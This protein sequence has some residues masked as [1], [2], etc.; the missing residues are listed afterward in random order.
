[1]PH[2][3]GIVCRRRGCSEGSGD[4]GGGARDEREARKRRGSDRPKGAGKKIGKVR[5]EKRE[6][7]AGKKTKYSKIHTPRPRLSSR[8]LNF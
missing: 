6:D 7:A 8:L 3:G 4:G 5:R 1:M 2:P